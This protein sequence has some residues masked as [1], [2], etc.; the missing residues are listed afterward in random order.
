MREE[1]CW[2][3]GKIDF[4]K[5]CTEKIMNTLRFENIGNVQISEF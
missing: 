2:E 1:R 4:Y 3:V 5:K